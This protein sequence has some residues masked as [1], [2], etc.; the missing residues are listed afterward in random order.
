MME[1]DQSSGFDW[2][3][4]IVCDPKILRGKPTLKGTRLAVEFVLD[5]L[6]G[7]W[8][9]KALRRNYPGLTPERK[10]AVLAY[11]ADFVRRIHTLCLPF[12]AA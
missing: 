8:D 4:Y 11:A 10:R 7:D 12:C 9:D 2:R 3:P 5:L 6:A 1:A